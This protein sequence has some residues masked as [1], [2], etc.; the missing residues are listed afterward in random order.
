M[1]IKK[2]TFSVLG[3]IFVILGVAGIF[4]PVL[5]TTPFLLLASACYFKGSDRMHA[6]LLNHRTL[7]PYIYNYITYR[8]MRKS[9]KVKAI[10]LLWLSLGLSLYLVKNIYVD[11]SLIIIGIGVTI[12]LLTLK[13]LSETEG[14]QA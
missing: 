8:A 1:P 4:M 2:I 10:G 12:Y 9:A 3:T 11:V 7:G 14:S 13:T 5:P 6:W